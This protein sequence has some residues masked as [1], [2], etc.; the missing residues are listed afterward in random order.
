MRLLG[1]A[2]CAA[3]IGVAAQTALADCTADKPIKEGKSSSNSPV[4]ITLQ[5]KDASVET[6]ILVR[7]MF[8]N[9]GLEGMSLSVCPNMMLCCVK[10]LHPLI[11]C[12]DTGIGLLDV[13]TVS[14]PT[15]HEVY[16]PRG[17]AFSFDLNIPPDRLPSEC[18]EKGRQISVC[19]C[20]EMEDGASVRSNVI[21]VAMK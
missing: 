3:Y 4:D 8:Q 15:S 18:A 21:Q 20:Y 19:V 17:S 16:L 10:G 14:R 12:E 1:V 6:G 5:L 11:T 9:S 7:V 2:L 13:C